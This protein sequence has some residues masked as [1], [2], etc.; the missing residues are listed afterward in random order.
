MDIKKILISK[1]H[2]AKYNP[3][4]DLQPGDEE[5]EKLKRSI[6][7]FDIVEPSTIIT[8]SP[9]KYFPKFHPE[10]WLVGRPGRK[11]HLIGVNIIYE[12][13]AATTTRA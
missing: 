6:E 4:K 1:I 8:A 7:E 5:Y 9:G 10:A 2:P 13:T 12:I 11:R 3:R